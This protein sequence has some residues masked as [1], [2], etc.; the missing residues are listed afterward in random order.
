MRSAMLRAFGSSKTRA[1]SSK[2][3]PCLARFEIFLASSHSM[4]IPFRTYRNVLH[5][6]WKGR[7][8]ARPSV[9]EGLNLRYGS[10]QAVS[11]CTER[12]MHPV[13]V[14]GW[15]VLRWLPEPKVADWNPASL[16]QVSGHG[17]NGRI[18]ADFVVEVRLPVFR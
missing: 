9:T 5:G 6:F 7:P 14:G 1:A 17:A 15:Q 8:V 10:N 4:C 2:L 3:T 16:A 18:E 11:V 12:R 13:T